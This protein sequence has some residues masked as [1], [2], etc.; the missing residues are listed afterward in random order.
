M[1]S[2][3]FRK[4]WKKKDERASGRKEESQ[5]AGQQGFASRH[6]LTLSDGAHTR[7]PGEQSAVRGL[8][9]WRQECQGW[10]RGCSCDLIMQHRV[11]FYTK[12]VMNVIKSSAINLQYS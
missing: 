4:R 6:G 5:T 7:Q 2:G 8:V 10:R 1:T 3:P 11:A 9:T 12:A